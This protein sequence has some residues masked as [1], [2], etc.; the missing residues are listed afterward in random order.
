[1]EKKIALLAAAFIVTVSG[2]VVSALPPMGPPKALVGQDQWAVGV[3]FSHSRMDLEASGTARED[4]DGAGWLPA[5]YAEHRIEDLTSNM[6]LGR[7]SYGAFDNVDVFACLGLSDAQDDM[8]EEL[9]TG[10]VGNQYSGLDCSHGFAWGF[11]ARATFWQESDI[12]W[13]GLVQVLWENPSDGDISLIPT[14]GD[15][16][17]MTGDAELDLLEIQVAVGPTVQ[18]NDFSVYGGP[19]LHFVSGDLDVSAAGAESIDP[20]AINRVELSQ[21]VDQESE[22]GFFVGAQGAADQETSWYVEFQITGDAWG[23]GV[24]GVRKF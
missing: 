13:G 24:G 23:V 22:F 12:T 9:A 3:G 5:S 15:P 20:T 14:D 2:S 17:R 8:T 6:V 4:P 18:V 19:F 7:L 10:G 16:S 11:G 1:M 21:D